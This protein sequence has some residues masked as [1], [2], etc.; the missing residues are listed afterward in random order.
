[1]AGTTRLKLYN[2]AL[3]LVGSDRLDALT[4][5]AETRH[6]IDDV[7]DDDFIRTVLEAGLWNFA[8]RTQELTPETDVTTPFGYR[9]AFQKATDWVRTAEISG[10]EF[11]RAPHLS[12]QDEIDFIFS[13][14]DKIWVRFVSDDTDWG[15]DL[16]RWPGSFQDYAA[17]Y[18]AS[19]IVHRL[20]SDKER[21]A[22]LITRRTGILDR[23]L[24]NAR[25]KDAMKDATQFL[26]TGSWVAARGRR[27]RRGPFG[28]GGVTG[29]LIG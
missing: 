16:S 6:L 13:D 27:A 19:Q 15:G 11:F 9:N 12:Y 14:F 24:K 10:D 26:P 23:A 20:T 18:L 25:A 3:R 1:M 5:D 28:D 4:D 17:A 8:M 21:I 7:Y 29:N 2:A 22:L